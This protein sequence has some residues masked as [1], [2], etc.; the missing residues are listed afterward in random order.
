METGDDLNSQL[1]GEPQEL[2]FCFFFTHLFSHFRINVV[3]IPLF[4]RCHVKLLSNSNFVLDGVHV[5][6]IFQ[7]TFT[8]C[9]PKKR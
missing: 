6:V 3:F 1:G 4:K 2:Q 5:F 7:I 9:V 8:L